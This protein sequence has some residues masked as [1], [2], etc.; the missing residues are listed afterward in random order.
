MH[1][2]NINTLLVACLLLL[3]F[4]SNAL[5]ETIISNADLK[6]ARLLVKTFG[7]E[8]KLELETAM[9]TGGPAK[10]LEVCHLQAGPIAKKLSLSSGWSVGRTSLKVR[11]I[12]NK[13]DE[14]EAMTLLQFEKRKAAGEDV[15][16]LEH[17]EIVKVDDKMVLRYMKTIP[18]AG[19][20]I[21]CHGSRLSED[22][23]KKVT[24]LYPYDQATGF[25]IGDIR[26]AFSLQKN[27]K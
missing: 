5:A 17:S 6:E 10:A 27:L 1:A 24:L 15:K 9:R 2:F 25:N 11:N 3:T 26:G 21:S 14:W 20:C 7:G 13:P 12:D 16:K 4:S 23:S 8:L 22:V 18:T 19:L